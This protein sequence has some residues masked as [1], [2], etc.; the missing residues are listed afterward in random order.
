M[1]P[2]LRRENSRVFG[3]QHDSGAANGGLGGTNPELAGFKTVGGNCE[4]YWSA[5]VGTGAE[6]GHGYLAV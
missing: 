5:P 3:S 2:T 4:W 6:G 1:A